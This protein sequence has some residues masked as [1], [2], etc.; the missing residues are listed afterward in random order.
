[1]DSSQLK[2]IKWPETVT[3][4]H[5]HLGGSV[6]LYRLWDMA[7]ER[8][9][10]GL[11]GGYEEFINV[12]KIDDSGIK[13]LAAYLEVYD[14]VELIQSGPQA[15]KESISISLQRAYRTGGMV[16]LGPGGE[17]GSPSQLFKIGRMELRWNP[18]K[19]T[20]AVF[21]KGEHAGLYD[22]DRVIKA[23]CEAIEDVEIGFRG[24]VEAGLIF[25]FGRDMTFEANRVLAEKT[26]MWAEKS[27]QIV[28]IDLAGHES[29]NNL[30]DKKKLAEMKELYDMLGDRVGKTVHVG[31]TRHVDIDTFVNTV[32]AL[33]P[34]RVAH[35]ISALR[36]FWEKKD[37]RGLKLLNERGIVCELCV[38]SN[39]LTGAVKEIAEYKKVINTLDDFEVAYTFSTDAPSLQVSSLGQELMMLLTNGAATEEQILRS[40]KVAD[41]STFLRR[42]R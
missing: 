16:E 2:N 30:S 39:I 14:T 32:E 28:G 19:R 4:N 6:P 25:C 10:R 9:I 22:V 31:E 17:G 13:D 34:D 15:V 12:L 3:E 18:M 7:I 35:P 26:L 36:A 11:G 1:M 27:G 41:E 37:D 5:V 23:A 29:I 8:G 42:K 40:L 33:N 24:D 38:R 21:L 20:G